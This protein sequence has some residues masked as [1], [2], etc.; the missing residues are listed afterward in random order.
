MRVLAV[1]RI[2]LLGARAQLHLLQSNFAAAR[3][4]VAAAAAL[5]RRCPT[6]LEAAAPEL[7]MQ[8]AL[9]AH[10][11]G[12]WGPA[13]AHYSAAAAAA[14]DLL[15]ELQAKTLAALARLAQGGPDA[16][17]RGGVGTQNSAFSEAACS[18]LADVY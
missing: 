11:V 17:A 15:M 14:P 10:A 4:D 13:V 9:Y 1:L 3:A 5:H 2:L 7:H 8:A 6:L 16:G 12:A 18:W